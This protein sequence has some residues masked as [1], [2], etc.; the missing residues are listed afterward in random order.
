M[1]STLI[2]TRGLPGCGKTTKAMRWVAED[3][4]GRCRVG[5]V[6]RRA[7]PWARKPEAGR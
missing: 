6:P 2:I 5:T 1:T 3:P 7:V 4:A